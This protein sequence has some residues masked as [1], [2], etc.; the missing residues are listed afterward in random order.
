MFEV[1]ICVISLL[2]SFMI[3]LYSIWW[4]SI[5][6]MTSI[7]HVISSSL[8]C[9]NMMSKGYIL[10]ESL[11]FVV[12]ICFIEDMK[13]KSL[14][15]LWCWKSQGAISLNSCWLL[16]WSLPVLKS[17]NLPLL[18]SILLPFSHPPPGAFRLLKLYPRLS[19]LPEKQAK[20]TRKRNLK[21]TLCT[22]NILPPKYILCSEW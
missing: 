22:E 6:L 14:M 12:L 9:C 21:K 8:C 16:N 13:C 15:H 19:G 4:K 18:S 10:W 11:M 2:L 17:I 7:L 3:I 20:Q 1:N 5:N